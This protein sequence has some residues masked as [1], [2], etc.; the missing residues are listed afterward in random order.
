[1]I[2]FKTID[3]M[4]QILMITL[5][6]LGSLSFRDESV[7]LMSYFIVGGWQILSVLVHFFYPVPF[8]TT[9]RKI[10]L[11]MLVLMLVILGIIAVTSP[12]GGIYALF[13]LLIVSPLLAIYYL[14]TCYRETAALKK[15]QGVGAEAVQPNP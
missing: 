12:D 3:Y 2:R 14:V 11:V 1:M 4:I 13:G 15:I 8:K 6:V 7:F 9:M 5:A 10:Y